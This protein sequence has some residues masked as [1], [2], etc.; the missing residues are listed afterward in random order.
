MSFGLIM[1][2]FNAVWGAVSTP[3]SLIVGM[4]TAGIGLRWVFR[5]F[6]K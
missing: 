5:V 2:A 6:L 3:I 4:V 1:E